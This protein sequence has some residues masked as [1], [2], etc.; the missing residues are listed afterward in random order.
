[1]DEARRTLLGCW[2]IVAHGRMELSGFMW[3]LG[4]FVWLFACPLI[5]IAGRGRRV[6]IR[7]VIDS[8]TESMVKLKN[9]S[10]GKNERID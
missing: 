1:M 2:R 10:Y 4:A 9:K 7:D 8:T 6:Y 5:K 3:E